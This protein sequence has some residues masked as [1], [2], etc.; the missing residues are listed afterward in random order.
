MEVKGDEPRAQRRR[1]AATTAALGQLLHSGAEAGGE[2]RLAVV[3]LVAEE[4]EQQRRAVDLGLLLD[5][6]AQR[7]EG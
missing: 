2:V 5:V 1:A 3:A 7:G 6:A 4:R